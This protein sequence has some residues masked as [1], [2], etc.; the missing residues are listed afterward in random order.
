MEITSLILILSAH[1]GGCAAIG[2]VLYEL[3]MIAANNKFRI[4]NCN[5]DD[6]L[7]RDAV[8]NKF[9]SGPYISYKRTFERGKCVPC[10]LILGWGIVAYVG[11][12]GSERGAGRPVQILTTQKLFDALVAQE[13]GGGESESAV[14]SD[15][16]Q[17]TTYARSGTYYWLT[18]TKRDIDMSDLRP[19]LAQRCTMIEIVG[20][21]EKNNCRLSVFLH[22]PP[23]GGKT[24]LAMMLAVHMG[25]TFCKSC[26]PCEPG[27]NVDKVLNEVQPSAKVPHVQLFDEFDVM[28]ERAHNQRV[29]PH[30]NMPV[31]VTDKRTMNNF[32]DDMARNRNV[33]CIFTS[34][35]SPDDI[36]C[37]TD[38]C[39]FRKGRVHMCVLIDGPT[40]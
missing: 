28:L 4:V 34:N 37:T 29:P 23:G 26:N 3:F 38:K 1:L 8:C 40:K 6:R 9:A 16:A 5:V 25:A 19:T 31:E 30:K 20:A 32:L 2:L 21:Y 12:N 15:T 36:G 35:R 24:S 33:V 22:G 11:E 10:G 14:T 17:L 39:Y 7:T 13:G 27:D 18:Y